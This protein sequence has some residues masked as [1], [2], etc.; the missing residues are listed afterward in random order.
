MGSQIYAI[1]QIG[2]SKLYVGP[3][4]QL[5]QRWPGIL[6]QLNQGIY[7]HPFVQSQW[8]QAEGTRTFSFHTA[9]ELAEAYD[10]S[11]LEEFLVEIGQL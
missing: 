4:H 6:S 1:A 5:R 10:V 3:A 8:Q 9:A 7:P 11:N 2:Q